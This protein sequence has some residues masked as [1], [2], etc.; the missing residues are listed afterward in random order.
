[1]CADYRITEPLHLHIE[2]NL[3]QQSIEILGLLEFK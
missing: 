1:M 3:R 2:E